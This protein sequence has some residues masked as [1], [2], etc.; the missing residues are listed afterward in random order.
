MNQVLETARH[1]QKVASQIAP[2]ASAMSLTG[3]GSATL[4]A[5]RDKQVYSPSMVSTTTFSGGRRYTSTLLP[6]V[7][8]TYRI[9]VAH[10]IE[11]A[12]KEIDE[13]K[14]SLAEL[15]QFTIKRRANLRAQMEEIELRIRE[16]HEARHELEIN[17]EKRWIDPLTGK[18]PAEK[19]I[20]FIEEWL[21]AADSVIEKLR[22]KSG[23]IKTQ[24][25]KARH[26]L[27]QREELGETLHP[28]DFQQLAI[29]NQDYLKQIEEKNQHLIDLKKITARYNIAL[30][31][32]KQKMA[33][34][35]SSLNNIRKEISLKKSQIDKLRQDQTI[36][37]A[38]VEKAEKQLAKVVH[39]ID[40]YEVPDILDFVKVQAELREMKK[41]Y[42]RLERHR[43]IQMTA[44]KTFRKQQ[45]QLELMRTVEN[46]SGLS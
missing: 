9:T 39:V 36:T 10:R 23:T 11:M 45:N 6:S 35:M 21:R 33:D 43:K 17:L 5:I 28:I 34:Q 20:R 15:E 40:E 2:M 30:T 13:M 42:K 7:P 37:R 24:I 29:E 19:F 12:S 4:S 16:T 8:K 27:R 41:T 18:I 22:L 1:A 31:S 25:K 46:K 44:L 32:Y 26:Q 14:K 3:S 38:E